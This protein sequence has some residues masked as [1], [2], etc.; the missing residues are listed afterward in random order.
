[1]SD[2][3]FGQE[4]VET[5]GQRPFEEFECIVLMSVKPVFSRRIFSGLKRLEFRRSRVRFPEFRT[6]I[7]VYES[8]PTQAIV[9]AF[10]VGRIFIDTVDQLW[11][12]VTK[13]GRASREDFFTY[14]RGATFG[15]A[16]EVKDLFIFVPTFR[17]RELERTGSSFRA[18]QSYCYVDEEFLQ[19]ILEFGSVRLAENL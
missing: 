5:R 8:R 16:L 1:M 18:P 9:G 4:L 6:L 17:K 10:G 12:T 7:L 15:T 2:N 11:N 19:S 14:F 3:G 13:S